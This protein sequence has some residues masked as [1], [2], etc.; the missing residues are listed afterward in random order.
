MKRV[1]FYI[2][3]SLCWMHSSNSLTSNVKVRWDH[4]LGPPYFNGA[5]GIRVL[6]ISLFRSI[7]EADRRCIYLYKRVGHRCS[8]AVQFSPIHISFLR[9]H[10]EGEWMSLDMLSTCS[11][12]SV[13]F[14][15][16]PPIFPP[17]RFSSSFSL[18]F[19]LDG[20]KIHNIIVEWLSVSCLRVTPARSLTSLSSHCGPTATGDIC[21]L[22]PSIRWFFCSPFIFYYCRFSSSLTFERTCLTFEQIRGN[23]V[24]QRLWWSRSINLC[25]CLFF[26]LLFQGFSRLLPVINYS[27]TRKS[28]WWH[29]KLHDSLFKRVV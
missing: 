29:G 22:M 1:S 23:N 28:I 27:Q 19:L 16:P 25:F 6:S 17:L 5:G 8:H 4:K 12:G 9:I 18:R 10:R 11:S 15:G 3:P 2:L 13:S 20:Q 7:Q 26:R 21:F 24:V 14:W